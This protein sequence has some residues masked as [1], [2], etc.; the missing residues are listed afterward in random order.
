MGKSA[1]LIYLKRK[2]APQGKQKGLK[3]VGIRVFLKKGA[4]ILCESLVRS[5]FVYLIGFA[6]RK[7]S[8][9][10]KTSKNG[11]RTPHFLSSRYESACSRVHGH[12]S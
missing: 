8:L 9:I 4:V 5:V 7:S 1:K 10:S 6:R 3:M 2:P 11:E 12:A